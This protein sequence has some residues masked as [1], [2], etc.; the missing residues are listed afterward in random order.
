MVAAAGRPEPARPCGRPELVHDCCYLARLCLLDGL[1]R[2][3]RL[4]RGPDDLADRE[5]HGT[6]SHTARCHDFEPSMEMMHE[7]GCLAFRPSPLA[8]DPVTW[9][10]VLPTHLRA[11][12]GLLSQAQ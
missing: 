4:S 9:I 3:A 10:S 2:P 5:V 11:D 8:S 6:G 12:E 1:V 7:H